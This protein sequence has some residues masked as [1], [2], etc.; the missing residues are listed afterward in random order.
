MR[1]FR[2][3][4]VF[5][6]MI[7]TLVTLS[8]QAQTQTAAMPQLKITYGAGLNYET[9]IEGSM[10]L[11]DTDGTVTALPAIFKTRG[12]TARKFTGKPSLNMKLRDAEGNEY[13]TPLLGLRK[14]S[15]FILDAMAIDRINMRNRVC[16]DIWNDFSRLPYETEFDSRNGTEGR[17]VE[18]F[19]NDRYKGIYCLSDKINRKLLDLKKPQADE[20]TGEVTI[21][22]LL[23]KNGTNDLGNQNTAGYFND[24][25][26]YVARYHDAW[27]LHEPEEYAS[28]EVWAP[29]A[30]LYSGS[31]SSS[32]D[33]VK[34][35]F[36]LENLADYT[37]HIMALCISDNWG[38]KNRY[39]SIQNISK[40]D[41]RSRFVLTP[42]DLDS[43]LGGNYNGDYYGGR[44]KTWAMGDIT[45]NPPTPLGAC[46]GNPEFKA[47]LK[48]RW[49]EGRLGAFSVESVKK[50]MTDYANLFIESGAWQ[51]TIDAYNSNDYIVKDLMEEVRM[52]GEWY[53]A[54]FAEMDRYFNVTEADYADVE[55]VATEQPREQQI[56]TLQGV[57]VKAVTAPGLYIVD[58][59][60]IMVK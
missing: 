50:R 34:K 31:N 6:L 52:I 43:S 1:H 24:Y 26:V 35:H 2:I 59:K 33:F 14:S 40:D 10:E 8:S 32:Y 38:A 44:Y 45:K 37:I 19:I 46:M 5:P 48:R 30:E 49:L 51:R 22:G 56:Y 15:T 36:W 39:F 7:V 28:E 13:D 53:E 21:R 41:E 57:R 9:Y 20:K 42:W 60:K 4:R 27:E 17:F 23:Y 11:T 55:A 25:T 18:L 3:F 47:L 54:R 12:A 58:G 16:F 29:L